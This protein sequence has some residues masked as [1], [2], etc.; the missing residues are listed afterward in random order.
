M[1]GQFKGAWR[2]RACSLR[3]LR[4]PWEQAWASPQEAERPCG[5]ETRPRPTTAPRHD[6]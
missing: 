6:Q 5:A 4:P 3:T 2:R 1:L